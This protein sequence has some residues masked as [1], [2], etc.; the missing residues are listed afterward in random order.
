MTHETIRS[1]IQEALAE[2]AP[3][4]DFDSID[5]SEDLR[6]A[7]DLDS[8]DFTNFIIALHRAF[9]IDIAESDYRKFFTLDGCYAEIARRLEG[10]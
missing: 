8:M 3:E 9:E 10:T 5:T 2:I 1:R 7:I 6:D 4:A